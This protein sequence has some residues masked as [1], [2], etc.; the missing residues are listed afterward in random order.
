LIICADCYAFPLGKEYT[1]LK[2]TDY[3]FLER[4][5]DVTKSNLFFAKGIILV[6]GWSEEILI[7]KIFFEN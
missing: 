7:P 2:A 6:E 3:P 1:K 5:L 4:F